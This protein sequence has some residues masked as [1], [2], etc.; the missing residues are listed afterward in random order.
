[1]LLLN[2]LLPLLWPHHVALCCI[3]QLAEAPSCA[4]IC[5]FFPAV[6]FK[7]YFQFIT[8][9]HHSLGVKLK[10]L[11]N[12]KNVFTWLVV[13][14]L[15]AVLTVSPKKQYLGTL[16]PTTP[17]T[18]GPEWIPWIEINCIIDFIILKNLIINEFL[19]NANLDIQTRRESHRS[20]MSQELKR[21]ISDVHRVIVRA[22]WS[23]AGCHV[24]STDSF[25]LFC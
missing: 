6:I 11:G 21:Y 2:K 18:A 4:G 1:M 13:C 23:S 14:I 25:H 17:A 16:I 22:I 3:D 15:E 5:E 24:Y 12:E 7:K 19:T 9:G 8:Y 20:N 10:G